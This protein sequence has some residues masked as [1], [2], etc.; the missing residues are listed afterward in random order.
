MY[1]LFTARPLGKHTMIKIAPSILAG[2]F[3]NLAREAARAE[4]A[5]ADLLHVDI[6]DGH[7]VPNL[8]VGPQAVAAIAKATKLPLDVHL[9][10]SRP[11][12]YVDAFIAAGA[13]MISVHVEANHDL[14]ATV[15]RLC[16]KGV[17]ASVVFNPDTPFHLSDAALDK[18]KMVLFMSVFPGFGGQKF[19]APV[20]EKIR[21]A[22]ATL[23]KRGIDIEIDGG[24]TLET[25]KA[26]V[27]AGANVLVS[28][29]ALYGSPDMKKTIE[30]MRAG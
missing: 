11:D 30:Q 12:L 7:F 29:T 9:M 10:L 18:I 25:A 1:R 6:M 8:T 19:I 27:A 2:D 13:A 16:A 21:G 28:G 23:R 22:K 5:G 14:E 20:L 15:N 4:E 26:A 3:G 17:R 24:V